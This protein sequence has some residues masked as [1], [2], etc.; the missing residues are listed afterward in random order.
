MCVCW[1]GGRGSAKL[2][3]LPGRSFLFA[4]CCKHINYGTRRLAT[5]DLFCSCRVILWGRSK[6]VESTRGFLQQGFSYQLDAADERLRETLP[7]LKTSNF[8]METSMSQRRQH[9]N[10]D[11]GPVV[12]K[13]HSSELFVYE[14]LQKKIDQ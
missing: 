13:L 1:W 12:S 4:R 6:S 7:N 11:D 2:K 5:Q 14:P 10:A 3:L 8:A 9:S